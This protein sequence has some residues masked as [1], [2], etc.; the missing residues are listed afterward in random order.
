MEH[1]KVTITATIGSVSKSV[2]VTV[3]GNSIRHLTGVTITGN[4]YVIKDFPVTYTAKFSPERISVDKQRWG[5][6]KDDGSAPLDL[7]LEYR[8]RKSEERICFGRFKRCCHGYFGRRY[9]TTC[10]RQE[11]RY[12]G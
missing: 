10:I 1:Q 3:R 9:N 7:R 5:L 6:T 4:D 2:E 12:K 11:R 8:R